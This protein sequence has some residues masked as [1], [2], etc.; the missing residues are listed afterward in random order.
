MP[1]QKAP[2]PPPAQVEQTSHGIRST[3][4]NEV[5]EVTVC[6][7]SVIHIVATPEPSANWP[8]LKLN[9]TGFSK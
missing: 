4:G 1:G 5:L 7:D 2:G 6:T 9:P 3:A 8:A